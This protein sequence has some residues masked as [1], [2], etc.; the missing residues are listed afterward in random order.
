MKNINENIVEFLSL[1]MG[2]GLMYTDKDVLVVE[3][4]LKNTLFGSGKTLMSISNSVLSEVIYNKARVKIS[5]EEIFESIN[6]VFGSLPSNV[7]TFNLEPCT[8][9]QFLDIYDPAKYYN[10]KAWILDIVTKYGKTLRTSDL[11]NWIMET[12]KSRVFLGDLNEPRSRDK[13]SID[14]VPSDTEGEG[15]L[16]Y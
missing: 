1:C 4:N 10:S 6:F 11:F 8:K 2:A 16:E 7:S 14:N 13:R 5:N 15:G 3:E 12:A 9:E